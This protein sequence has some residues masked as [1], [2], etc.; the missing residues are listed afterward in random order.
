MN[1]LHESFCLCVQSFQNDTVV[2]IPENKNGKFYILLIGLQAF[3]VVLN[4]GQSKRVLGGDYVLSILLRCGFRIDFCTVTCIET[5][6]PQ[7]G[8]KDFCWKQ[9]CLLEAFP[10][11]HT[12]DAKM[13]LRIHAH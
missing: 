5:C 8:G 3:H 11:L 4:R 12:A 13:M 6:C 2:K 1:N 10:V 9:A 7:G